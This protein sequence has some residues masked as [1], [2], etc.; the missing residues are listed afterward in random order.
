MTTKEI[1]EA[2]KEWQSENKDCRSIFAIVGESD[3]EYLAGNSFLLGKGED[4]CANI[5]ESFLGNDD[6]AQ[7]LI[8]SILAS[9]KTENRLNNLI[10][11]SK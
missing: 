7:V 3:G 10:K 6:V 9:S 5:A 8:T 2:I 4:I 1:C 11:K